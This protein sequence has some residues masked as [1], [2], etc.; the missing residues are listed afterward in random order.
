MPS[1]VLHQLL[2]AVGQ[3][4]ASAADLPARQDFYASPL[5]LLGLNPPVPDLYD[6]SSPMPRAFPPREPA[7][8]HADG[9]GAGPVR[10]AAGE[11]DRARRDVHEQDSKMFAR[12]GAAARAAQQRA[13][14][15][16][17]AQRAFHDRMLLVSRFP[18]DPKT[19][20]NQVPFR[21]VHFLEALRLVKAPAA[22]GSAA[23]TGWLGREWLPA[24]YFYDTR[25]QPE[26]KGGAVCGAFR[27]DFFFAY[28]H[29]LLAMLHGLR[30][31]LFDELTAVE[32]ADRPRRRAE[33]LVRHLRT[34]G[35]SVPDDLLG[36]ACDMLVQN[37]FET[38]VAPTAR[39]G[40]S[41]LPLREEKLQF[42]GRSAALVGHYPLNRLD[43]RLRGFRL[44]SLLR[45]LVLVSP[46]CTGDHGNGLCDDAEAASVVLAGQARFERARRLCDDDELQAVA[47][48][49]DANSARPTVRELQLASLAAVLERV[50]M[51]HH[52][53]AGRPSAPVPLQDEPAPPDPAW[54]PLLDAGAELLRREVDL[55]ARAEDAPPASPAV[56]SPSRFVAP[57]DGAKA[58][59]GGVRFTVVNSWMLDFPPAT[60]RNFVVD[61]E[62]S[63][64]SVAPRGALW[65]PVPRRLR[66]LPVWVS[67]FRH[68]AGSGSAASQL[69]PLAFQPEDA[70][71]PPEGMAHWLLP[72]DGAVL[73][74]GW[75][76]GQGR[77]TALACRVGDE[78]APQLL[79]LVALSA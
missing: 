20:P 26:N 5:A 6:A 12:G 7:T 39:G 14:Q 62:R 9:G 17:H 68:E 33:S 69:V 4:E 71:E 16:L 57:S 24:G 65:L 1:P 56:S 75:N 35:A 79:V 76:D 29:L 78:H 52:A 74:P 58:A 22:D 70:I 51:E 43:S 25:V 44:P 50:I 67:V 8:A 31:E 27:K 19:I 13:E 53:N 30:P 73:P 38:L 45:A 47:V 21:I 34:L 10:R 72:D 54:Q 36:A 46:A 18:L 23:A 59:R 28:C 60:W 15:H 2:V 64:Q 42:R 41:L 49:P 3:V 66:A 11:L 32:G 61:V 77:A 55:L 48:N 37:V 40:L 63:E